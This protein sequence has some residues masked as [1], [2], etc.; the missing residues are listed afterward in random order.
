M[1]TNQ[2][3]FGAMSLGNRIDETTSFALLDR[4]VERGGAWIDTADCYAFWEAPSGL[5]GDAEAVLGRWFAARPGVRD[6]V[7]ISTKVG[8]DPMVAHQWPSSAEGLS[9]AAIERGVKGSLQRMGIERVEL[10]WAHMEDRSVDLAETVAAFGQLVADGVVERLGASNHPTWRVERARRIAAD[11]GVEPYTA[12]QLRHSYLHPRPGVTLPNGG[13]KLLT[14][15]MIDYVRTEGDL[16]LWAYTTQLMGAYAKPERLQEQYDHPGT[17]ARLAVL[18]EVAAEVDATPNQVVLSWLMG[19]DPVVVPIVGA[20]TIA[21]LDEALDAREL[22]L[23]DEQR[24]R[25]DAPA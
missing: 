10:L 5:G 18:A 22:V 17:T 14:E 16:A 4:W 8:A 2:L 19:G 6:R 13:H 3:A 12:V 15:E 9:R 23:T 21:Q 20:S 11:A 25:L 7:R 1:T 24:A